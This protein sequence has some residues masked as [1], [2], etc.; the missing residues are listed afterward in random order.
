MM[1]SMD[2]ILS[3]FDFSESREKVYV[4]RFIPQVKRKTHVS[5]FEAYSLP[6]LL[7]SFFQ[8]SFVF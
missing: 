8:I 4:P 1:I 3:Q 6:N 5:G 2:N 7:V